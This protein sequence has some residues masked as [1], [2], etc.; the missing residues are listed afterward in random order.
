[1]VKYIKVFVFELDDDDDD[2]DKDFDCILYRFGYVLLLVDN[3]K[4]I[5]EIFFFGCKFEL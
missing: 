5:K 2:D 3:L 1:M 4:I